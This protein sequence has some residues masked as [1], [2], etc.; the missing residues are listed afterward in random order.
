M[1]GMVGVISPDTSRYVMFW[2]CLSSLEKPVN[3]MPAWAVTSD[4]IIGRNSC[5]DQAL[6]KGAEWLLFLDDDHTF[7]SN[8]LMRLLSHNV[9]IAGAL[10]FQRQVPFAPVAYEHKTEDEVYIP[11]NLH[12]H[13]ENDLVEV[14][15]LGTGGMLIRSE[16]FH[17]MEKPYFEHGRASED[18][19]FCDKARELGFPVYCD[20]GARMGHISPAALWPAHDGTDWQVGFSFTDGFSVTLPIERE[21]AAA[22]A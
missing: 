18:L 4:R 17:A 1:A 15:A 10:Y 20:L 16:V 2:I 8:I 11:L 3:T 14:V 6:D 21:D 7:S 22:T 5:V 12:N 19:I 9:P 13:G